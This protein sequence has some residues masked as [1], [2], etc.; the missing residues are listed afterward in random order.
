MDLSANLPETK[1][2]NNNH[3][4]VRSMVLPVAKYKCE[5]WTIKK[6]ERPRIDAFELWS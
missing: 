6:A 2:S 5:S 1:M 3:V 4:L